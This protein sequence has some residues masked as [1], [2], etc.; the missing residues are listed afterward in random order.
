MT[1]TEKIQA[2]IEKNKIT[3]E[4]IF[5]PFSKSRNAVAKPKFNDYCLNWQVTILKDSK[6]IWTGDYSAGQGHCPTYKQ[7]AVKTLEYTEKIIHECEKG[8]KAFGFG[9]V[10][11]LR[12]RPQDRILPKLRDVL[13]GISLD[14]QVIDYKGFEDWAS[15]FGY[16][17]D[18]RKAE[19]I[20]DS[21]L[22]SALSFRNG[23]GDKALR[24]L[25]EACQDY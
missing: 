20:Y 11:G 3:M 22:K 14:S 10:F 21:C 12:C 17:T 8:F 6:P 4:V 24:N 2:W 1:P 25:S 7:S 9:M 5:V 16:D 13:Y 18:S 19:K 23:L 15:N